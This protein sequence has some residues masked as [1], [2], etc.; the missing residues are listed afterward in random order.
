MILISELK[1]SDVKKYRDIC[2]KLTTLALEDHSKIEPTIKILSTEVEKPDKS[3]EMC[4]A[5]SIH[6]VKLL[7]QYTT[8][9]SEFCL[10]VS[11]M[12]YCHYI[13]FYFFFCV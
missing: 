10:I 6:L 1:F 4:N 13:S 8:L 5:I 9:P 3:N 2:E 11:M 7:D 12:N